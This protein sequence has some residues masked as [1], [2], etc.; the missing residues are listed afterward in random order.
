MK[1]I[2]CR[3]KMLHNLLW[4]KCLRLNR[5]LYLRFEKSHPIISLHFLF[6]VNWKST[7]MEDISLFSC[8]SIASNAVC[9]LH[10]LPVKDYRELFDPLLFTKNKLIKKLVSVHM[11]YLEVYTSAEF[12]LSR[13]FSSLIGAKEVAYPPFPFIPFLYLVL[14]TNSLFHLKYMKQCVADIC[15]LL[16]ST[17]IN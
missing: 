1:W 13:R 17:K 16:P 14:T 5:K 4:K 15:Q 2:A 6:Y 7:V 8:R 12:F 3:S 11:V 10:G 9:L